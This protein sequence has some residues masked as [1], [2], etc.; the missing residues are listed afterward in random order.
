VGLLQTGFACRTFESRG[1]Y[2]PV[3]VDD[4]E[5]GGGC[6]VVPPALVSA[7]LGP[8]PSAKS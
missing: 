8:S 5:G 6:P 7:A 1:A 3:S 4:D 2:G